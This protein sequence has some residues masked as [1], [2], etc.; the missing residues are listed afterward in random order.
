MAPLQHP[1][2]RQHEVPDGLLLAFSSYGMRH[3]KKYLC[4]G[5]GDKSFLYIYM[6]ILYIYINFVNFVLSEFHEDALK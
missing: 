1:L 3:G 5:N 4:S 2:T 6:I